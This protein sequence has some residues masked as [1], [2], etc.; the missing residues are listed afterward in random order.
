[1]TQFARTN[2]QTPNTV[3][4]LHPL[5]HT[6]SRQHH[7]RSR[8]VTQ[9]NTDQHESTVEDSARKDRPFARAVPQLWHQQRLVDL[10]PHKPLE[11]LQVADPL[12]FASSILT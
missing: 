4:V 10:L 9:A 8:T 5:L 2:D 11:A 1:M 6:I 12:A 3:Q 7:M